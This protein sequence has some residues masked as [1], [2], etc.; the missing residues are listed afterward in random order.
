MSLE[1]FGHGRLDTNGIKMRGVTSQHSL[2]SRHRASS[3][4]REL[5]RTPYA[6]T[7]KPRE[8][9]VEPPDILTQR[10]IGP[11]IKAEDPETIKRAREQILDPFEDDINVRLA[12]ERLFGGY[13]RSGSRV[14][15]RAQ[16][17]TIFPSN[18]D[19]E[20]RLKKDGDQFESPLFRHN[21]SFDTISNIS[22][23]NSDSNS[24]RTQHNVG[25]EIDYNLNK[26]NVQNTLRREGINQI[27]KQVHM[28]KNNDNNNSNNNNDYGSDKSSSTSENSNI[29]LV[30][31]ND[32]RKASDVSFSKPPL[33]KHP[34]VIQRNNFGSDRSVSI[35]TQDGENR[36]E[37]K[38]TLQEDV[39][40]HVKIEEEPAFKL[41]EFVHLKTDFD[42]NHFLNRQDSLKV[43]R[44]GV[45]RYKKSRELAKG[46]T[47]S[48][49]KNICRDNGGS[50]DSEDTV[51]G[52]DRRRF[53]E[54]TVAQ[55]K[56]RRFSEDILNSAHFPP[57]IAKESSSDVEAF[58]VLEKA[59]ILP[60]QSSVDMES[61]SSTTSSFK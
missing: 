8:P 60:Q 36:N 23:K 14:G 59:T 26:D 28:S 51:V 61:V 58:K 56:R 19:F 24:I 47:N 52:E 46:F 6:F 53:S 18:V 48:F 13:S 37:A 10:L 49:Y 11:D 16:S 21:A 40:K 15:S 44:E 1:G 54:E 25:S 34:I 9:V 29:S 33:N 57:R 50:Q 35:E 42:E 31:L 43:S 7:P 45:E 3:V 38:N 4:E 41:K 2:F 20:K 32:V 30:T 39:K 12:K 17:P 27:D 22:E 55:D 5:A